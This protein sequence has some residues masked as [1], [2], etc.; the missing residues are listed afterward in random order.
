MGVCIIG[1]SNS[2]ALDLVIGDS[3]ILK[4]YP[5]RVRRYDAKN[6]S[7]FDF[8]GVS[9]PVTLSWNDIKMAANG[10][11]TLV[12]EPGFIPGAKEVWSGVWNKLKPN[13]H[14]KEGWDCVTF[15]PRQENKVTQ[16]SCPEYRIDGITFRLER[17]K[18]CEAELKYIIVPWLQWSTAFTVLIYF[19]VAGTGV[20]IACI[21][22]YQ[23]NI[24]D[25]DKDINN[26]RTESFVR[27]LDKLQEEEDRRRDGIRTKAGS[28]TPTA[29]ALEMTHV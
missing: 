25:W 1:I 21:N 20:D 22:C 5:V 24:K 3:H 6:E 12:G 14:A 8:K 28:I 18:S 4:S 23:C 29:V 17:E 10:N 7:Y 16:S 11:K 19:A 15:W 2:I 26:I 27:I 13:K 9:Y